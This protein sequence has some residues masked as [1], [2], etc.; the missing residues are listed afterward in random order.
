MWGTYVITL[1]VS[2]GSSYS[3]PSNVTIQVTVTRHSAIVALQY[4]QTQISDLKPDAFKNAN[5]QNALLNKLNAVIATIDAGNYVDALNQLQQDILGKVTGKNSWITN[6]A[7]QTQIYKILT[8]IIAEL[9][10]L[11]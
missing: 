4:L 8:P 6:P 5:M 2:N 10:A 9:K 3:D 7:A 1:V 11:S